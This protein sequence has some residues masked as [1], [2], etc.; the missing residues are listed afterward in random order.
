[1]KQGLGSSARLDPL[2]AI[3]RTAESGPSEP[4]SK[5]LSIFSSADLCL[6][7]LS[8]AHALI[9]VHK[10]L[11]VVSRGTVPWLLAQ[12]LCNE[13]DMVACLAKAACLYERL[14]SYFITCVAANLLTS[15]LWKF[16]LLIASLL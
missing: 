11:N 5:N 7:D 9:N 13:F 8:E 3:D 15:M 14:Q 10:P 1:M 6:Q 4:E 2:G 16:V 12:L